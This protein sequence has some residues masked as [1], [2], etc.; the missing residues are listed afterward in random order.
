MG[1]A[2][3]GGGRRRGPMVMGADGDGGRRR[4][5]PMRDDRVPEG[6]GVSCLC[7]ESGPIN[8]PGCLYRVH[9]VDLRHFNLDYY[10][11]SSMV[12][13]LY[14]SACFSK[15]LSIHRCR[16]HTTASNID[17]PYTSD[18]M[19]TCLRCKYGRGIH[20]S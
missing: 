12:G 6:I 14:F 10:T 17:W 1:S 4:G 7:V 18:Y 15:Q 5:R 3:E 9:S 8:R 13:P 20:F 19:P 11:D 16:A 2:D